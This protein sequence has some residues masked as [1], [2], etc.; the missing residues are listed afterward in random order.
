MDEWRDE[1]VTAA[2]FQLLPGQQIG[3]ALAE[4]DAHCTDSGQDPQ[5]AF[6]DPAEYARTLAAGRRPA[7]RRWLGVTGVARALGGVGGLL[8]LLDGLAAVRDRTSATITAGQLCAIGVAT[9]AIA[10]FVTPAVL[11]AR[12]SLRQQHFVV[13]ATAGLGAAM[14]AVTVW[15]APA[16]RAPA[17]PLLAA[18]GVA[19]VAAYWPMLTRRVTSDRIIDPRTGGEPFVLPRRARWALTA[20]RWSLPALLACAVILV[21]VFG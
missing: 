7:R 1:F 20:A 11:G 14:L 9:I 18:G 8:I 21:L 2:R 19:A 6:G 12:V 10:A 16:I 15:T 13:L 17:W 4:I 5:Q 3:D